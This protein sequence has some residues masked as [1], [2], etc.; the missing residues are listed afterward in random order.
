MK[1]C[2]NFQS[3]RL[4]IIYFKALVKFCIIIEIHQIWKT[5]LFKKETKD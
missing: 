3:N 5:E 1:L 2:K 4:F